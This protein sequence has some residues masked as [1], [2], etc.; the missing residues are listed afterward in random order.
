[1]G[2]L[3]AFFDS[4]MNHNI[5]IKI[6]SLYSQNFSI[7]VIKQSFE[8]RYTELEIVKVIVESD[9]TIDSDNLIIPSA[10]NYSFSNYRSKPKKL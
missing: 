8:K 3:V 9:I 10:M 6:I 4:N 1:V 2:E 7:N 5:K